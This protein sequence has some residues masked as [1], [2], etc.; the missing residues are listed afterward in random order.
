MVWRKALS[1]RREWVSLPETQTAGQLVANQLMLAGDGR[2]LHTDLVCLLSAV[3][4][5]GFIGSRETGAPA[6]IERAPPE[7]PARVAFSGFDRMVFAGL[8]ALAPNGLDALRI[9]KTATVI[10]W[11][12]AG[13]RPYWR[14]KSRSRG[15]RPRIPGEIRQLIRDTGT[16]NP[17]WGAPRIHGELLKLGIEVGQT[18]VAS[19]IGQEATPTVAGLEDLPSQ[20]CRRHRVVGSVCRAD[21]FVS[22]VVWIA[23]PQH[24]RRELPGWQSPPIRPP[25]GLRGNLQRHSAGAHR[26]AVDDAQRPGRRISLCEVCTVGD[27]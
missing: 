9:V 8:Y 12:R 14:W 23:D 20:S 27:C 13:F 1:L 7:V 11:H 17:L 24:T 22:A 25:N 18:T 3:A 21:D 4:V 26:A 6:P 2:P 10:R 15:G 19:Y 16:A 5:A